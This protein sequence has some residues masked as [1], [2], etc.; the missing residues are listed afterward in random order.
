MMKKLQFKLLVIA[1]IIFFVSCAH[2]GTPTGGPDDKIAPSVMSS[3]PGA[4][5]VNVPVKTRISIVFTEWLSK[6]SDR[7]ISIYPPMKIKTVVVRNRL[8][9]IP[10]GKLE[11]S[12]TYHISITSQLQDLHN[13]SILAPVSLTFSTGA[14]LDSGILGGCIIDPSRK[15]LQ[16]KVALFKKEHLD[17]DSGFS[18]AP[19]YLIQTD[20]SGRFNF[21]HLKFGSYYTIAFTDANSDNRIAPITEQ[22][23]STADSLIAINASTKPVF[24]FQSSYDTTKMS[25]LNVKAQSTTVLSG[26]WIIPFDLRCGYSYPQCKVE[27]IDSPSVKYQGRY[28]PLSNG[29]LFTYLLKNPIKIT[30]YRLIYT[31]RTPQAVDFTDT[32]TFNGVNTPDTLLPALASFTPA[33]NSITDLDPEIKLIWTEPV[34]VNTL[35]FLTDSAGTDSINLKSSTGYSD[36]TYLPLKRKLRPDTKYRMVLLKNIAN[37]FNG[38]TLKARD[39]TDTVNV[40]NFKTIKEDSIAISLQGAG[41]CNESSSHRKWIF[42][43]L[44]KSAT[45][46]SKDSSGL[47][48]FDSIYG[49]NGLISY[50]DDLNENNRVDIGR[51]KPWFGP[52]PNYVAPDTIEARARWDVDGV[53]VHV[54]DPCLK[55]KA[56][57]LAADTTL[58]SSKK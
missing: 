31:M 40:L 7:G 35:L 51:I 39:S 11:D 24:L 1:G 33:N 18:G 22:V 47:F 45:Y 56:D 6:N 3:V 37:D 20:S 43:P 54:C 8:D 29:K 36:T 28:I 14:V 52:E 32:L 27:M 10:I 21:I 12:T 41:D 49:G 23:Y 53:I 5:S 15:A 58:K 34:A 13:N 42:R 26:Q 4:E 2:Q 19:D 38:N 57:S 25:L 50:F 46:I 9:I 48:R 44:N 55:L 17:P 30:P 16:P